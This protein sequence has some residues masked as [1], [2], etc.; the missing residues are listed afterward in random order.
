MDLY[1]LGNHSVGLLHKF[2]L[3]QKEGSTVSIR[4]LQ[5]EDW[6]FQNDLLG[7][8]LGILQENRF[9]MP[10]G[11]GEMVLSREL[12]SL[13][14]WALF[15]SLPWNLPSPDDLEGE[16]PHPVVD[17]LPDFKTLKTAFAD[18]EQA[19]STAFSGTISAYFRNT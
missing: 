17:H 10:L 2:W 15:S 11:E 3:H 16:I 4:E 8:C 18:V 13:D 14:M 19:S 9:I 5:E 7:R 12:D 1:L 6:V